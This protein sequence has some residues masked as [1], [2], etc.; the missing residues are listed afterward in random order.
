M[1]QLNSLYNCCNYCEYFQ[2]TNDMSGVCNHP[3]LRRVQTHLV[4]YAE[5]CVAGCS[6]TIHNHGNIESPEYLQEYRKAMFLRRHLKTDIL[7]HNLW[8]NYVTTAIQHYGE[9]QDRT[10]KKLPLL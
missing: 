10:N 8:N 7:C 9:Q 3:L 1:E 4:L 5:N 6:H 2:P